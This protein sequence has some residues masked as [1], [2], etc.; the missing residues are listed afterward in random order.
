MAR[1]SRLDELLAI[2]E[3][4]LREFPA[5]HCRS[6]YGRLKVLSD[7]LSRV[8]VEVERRGG[9]LSSEQGRR[10]RAI[11]NAVIEAESRWANGCIL[12]G[13]T[14]FGARGRRR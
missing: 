10:R 6:E 4:R 12:D 11:A 13:R 1:R 9:R 8:Q 2:A 3:V 14:P 7:L 5:S